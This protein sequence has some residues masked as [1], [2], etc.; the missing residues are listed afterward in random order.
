MLSNLTFKW[1]NQCGKRYYI[2]GRYLHHK[3]IK[4]C[5]LSM[6]NYWVSYLERQQEYHFTF[7]WL[8]DTVI[9]LTF[10]NS[11]KIRSKYFE[12]IFYSKEITLTQ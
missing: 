11:F 4:V 5:A 3:E 2:I 10:I 8:H 6:Q 12:N 1:N 9:L 7:N